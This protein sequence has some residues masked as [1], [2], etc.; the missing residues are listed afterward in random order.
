VS[1][2]GPDA[3]TADVRIR[4]AGEADLTAVEH[5]VRTAYTPWAARIGREPAPMLDDYRSLIEAGRVSVAE[6]GGQIAGV[7]VLLPQADTMLLDNVAVAPEA[8]GGGLGRLLLDHAEAAARAA[9]FATVTLYTNE[10]MAENIALYARC[11]YLETERR[12]DKGHR[13]VYMRKP[14]G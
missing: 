4:A 10:L 11:G 7:L 8:Q 13:R 14:L 9:G 6:A 5:V 3:G 2:R 12:Q 1:G